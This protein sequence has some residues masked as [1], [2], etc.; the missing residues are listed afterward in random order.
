MVILIHL[1]ILPFIPSILLSWRRERDCV[2]GF[3]FAYNGLLVEG[4]TRPL[5]GLAC[6]ILLVTN[7]G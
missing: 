7:E 3:S 2:P 6:F 5:L 1:T 4:V